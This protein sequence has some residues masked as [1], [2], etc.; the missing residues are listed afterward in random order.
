MD[1]QTSNNKEKQSQLQQQLD[2]ATARQQPEQIILANTEM[3]AFLLSQN[4]FSEAR[5]FARAAL[6]DLEELANS[7][8]QLEAAVYTQLTQTFVKS[9]DYPLTAAYSERLLPLSRQLED[10]E[11]E[12]IALKNLGIVAAT[13]AN[14]KEAMEYFIEVLEKGKAASATGTTIRQMVAQCT[15]NIATIYANLFNYKDALRRYD[16]VLSDY[17]DVLSTNTR[18]IVSNNVG[19]L[20]LSNGANEK[21]LHYF[22]QSYELAHQSGTTGSQTGAQ[23]NRN[24]QAHALAQISRALLAM[25]RL[26]QASEKA[27]AAAALIETLGDTPARAINLNNFGDICLRRGDFA[28]AGKYAGKAAAAAKSADDNTNEIRAYK[29]LSAIF[30]AQDDF[31]QALKYQKIYGE[32]QLRFSEVQRNRMALDLEI[33]YSLKEKQKAIE[34]LRRENEY[35]AILLENKEEIARQNE[36]LTEANEE[37]KQFAYVASHDLKEPLRMIGSYTQ[38]IQKLFAKEVDES[39]QSY[40][41]Y[42]SG[43][44]K[45]MNNLLDA[46]LQYATIGRS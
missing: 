36:Q 16:D 41:D 7:T 3:S 12:I 17:A 27:E 4:N 43:G 24:T 42:V 45:R 15:I 46:L 20:Y 44:V 11:K 10:V 37:L 38:L 8:P 21:A 33:N 13:K 22:E 25:G 40:F 9:Y 1:I 26:E 18:S 19:N 32:M 29:L 34:D 39:T 35:Q 28:K 14:Y 2:E 6:R 30:E 5:T 23:N 31:K